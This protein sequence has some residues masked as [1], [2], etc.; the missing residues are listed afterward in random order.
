[1]PIAQGNTSDSVPIVLSTAD[2]KAVEKSRRQASNLER[3]KSANSTRID[4]ICTTSVYLDAPPDRK[5]STHFKD[6]FRPA[7]NVG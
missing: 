7:I 4:A 6:D 2:Q 5:P 3:I 1:M